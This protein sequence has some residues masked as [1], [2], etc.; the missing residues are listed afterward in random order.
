[1]QGMVDV[2]VGTTRI[3]KRSCY[4]GIIVPLSLGTVPVSLH[5]L[6]STL[7]MGMKKNA[8]DRFMR[9]TICGCYCAER[10]FLL[11][12]TMHYCWPLRSWYTVCR[13]FRPWSTFANNGRRASVMCFIVSEHVLDLEIQFSIGFKE[14]GEN[15]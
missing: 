2:Q 5:I 9:D 8:T 6:L 4:Q 13:V 10:F 7:L 14:E 3:R 12:H 1:M 15:W 11:Y